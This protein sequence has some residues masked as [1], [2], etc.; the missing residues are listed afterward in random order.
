METRPLLESGLSILVGIFRIPIQHVWG[1]ID[2]NFLAIGFNDI[3]WI[4]EK[5]ISVNHGD[6]DLAI[7]QFA[8]L[9]SGSWSDLILLAKKVEDSMKLIVSSFRRH[10]VVETGDIIQGRDRASPVRWNAVT[11]MADQE[12]EMELLQDLCRH[13]GGIARLFGRIVRIRCLMMPVDAVGDSVD[14]S[15]GDTIGLA[16]RDPIRGT[17]CHSICSNTL[18][19]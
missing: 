6:A 14:H 11:R 5:V 4:V 8:M 7:C 9:A 19:D 15:V 1:V 12:R 17:V 2:S 3:G 10:E 18:L 13:N 16:V